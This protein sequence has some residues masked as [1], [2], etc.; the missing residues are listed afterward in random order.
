PLGKTGS[1]G[2]GN[3]TAWFA[4]IFTASGTESI[5]SVGFHAASAGSTYDWY[6]YTGVTTG[7]RTGTLAASGS[8]LTLA[9]PGYHVVPVTPVPVT[10][11]QKFSVVIRLTTPGYNYPIPMERPVAGYTSQA[12]AAAGQSFYSSSGAGWSDL[13][14]TY[15]NSNVTLKALSR[16]AVTAGISGGN[17][18]IA[19]ANPAYA[20]SGGTATFDLTPD[21]GYRPNST[22]TGTCQAGS[23]FNN[24]YTTGLI[25]GN[26][27]I[28]FTFVPS[29][30]YGL[31]LAVTGA[32][33]SVSATPAPP[34]AVCPPD[35]SLTFNEGNVVT[36]TPIPGSGA[37]FSSWSGACSGSGS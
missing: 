23:L 2:Y 32:G 16:F 3:E 14:G 13:T 24:T 22:V 10:T 34:G 31:N 11:G 37:A 12:V 7:P 5:T 26:C 36:L 18:S 28:I 21:L 20:G 6:I 25:T 35:C 1:L 4:N 17:G 27:N 9:E 33:G 8:G 29:T 30:T 15:A 19:S